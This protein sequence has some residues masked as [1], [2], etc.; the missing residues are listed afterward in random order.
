MPPPIPLKQSSYCCW[1]VR[2]KCRCLVI[3]PPL[4]SAGIGQLPVVGFGV[5]PSGQA[6]CWFAANEGGQRVKIWA[7]KWET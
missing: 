5:E 1:G 3:G 4:L 7:I 6:V 2:L